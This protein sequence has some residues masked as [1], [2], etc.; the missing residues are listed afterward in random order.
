MGGTALNRLNF[1]TLAEF[2]RRHLGALG[3]LFV[4]VLKLCRSAGLVKLGHVA[5]DGTKIQANA[6]KHKAMSYRRMREAEAKLAAEVAVRFAR[7]AAADAAGGPGRRPGPGGGGLA[8][9]AAYEQARLQG[10]RPGHP[11]PH[12]GAPAAAA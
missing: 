12:R 9:L 7:P 4:Q 11:A 5:L 10:L 3:E 8:A 6:S 1:R 2:R